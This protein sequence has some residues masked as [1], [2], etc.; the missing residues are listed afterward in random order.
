[1]LENHLI[2]Q[3]TAR[4]YTIGQLTEQTRSVWFCLHGYGQLAQYFGRKFSELDDG[5]TM[6]VVPEGLS[7]FYLNNEYKRIGASWQTR[8]DREHEIEDLTAY[9]NS[10]YDRILSPDLNLHITVL[11]F[12]QGAA[13]ACRWL[14]HG[15]IR[16]DRLILWAGYFPDGLQNLV[17]LP[18][19]ASVETH[20]V[21][22][23]QDAYL[24][25]LNKETFLAQIQTDIPAVS[26]TEFN[27]VHTVD[28]GVLK[29][30][31]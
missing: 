30:F 13:T 29:K 20:Y 15:H 2:V 6:V 22:G 8:E 21:Y 28:T 5:R 1:M 4:Y 23:D 16:I 17:D 24:L 27:G 7:R 14:N 10:L 31:I 26:I 3:R 11:G 12:S 25:T 18:R 9:L 19:L